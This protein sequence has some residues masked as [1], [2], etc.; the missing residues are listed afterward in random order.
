MQGKG[1]ADLFRPI[2]SNY[3]FCGVEIVPDYNCFGIF[4]DGNI[5][6]VLENYPVHLAK[7]FDL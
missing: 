4:K 5:A 1:T 3:R 6:A 7:V 2:T